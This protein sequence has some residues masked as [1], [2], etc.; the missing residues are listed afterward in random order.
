MAGQENFIKAFLN[1]LSNDQ[2]IQKLRDGITAPLKFDYDNL[3]ESNTKLL[4]EVK[5]LQ[6][7]NVQLQQKLTQWKN[8]A[9]ENEE[10]IIALEKKVKELEQDH[11]DQEQYSRRNSIRIQGLDEMPQEN[12][13]ER[14][15]YLAQYRL[16]V[17]LDDMDVDAVYRIG[18]RHKTRDIIVKFTTAR[19]RD[20]VFKARSSLKRPGKPPSEI[21]PEITAD[22]S[23]ER[24]DIEIYAQDLTQRRIFMNEDLTKHRSHILWQARQHK[25]QKLLRDCWSYGGKILIKDKNNEIHVVKSIQELNGKL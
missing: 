15:K 10:K 5:I 12:L 16:N 3:L 2:V 19:A 11:D 8:K 1:A 14:I 21:D 6:D 17:V 7:S 24:E 20:L 4:A 9:T 22:E 23:E 25:K 18:P 13:T